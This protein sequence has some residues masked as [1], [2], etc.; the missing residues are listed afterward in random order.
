MANSSKLRALR[1]FLG[2]TGYY[3]KFIRGYALLAAPLTNLLKKDGFKWD[4]SST[5]AFTKLKMAM[6]IPPV[7]ALPDFTQPFIIECDAS[8][9][10]LGVVLMPNG[11]PLAFFSQMLHGK[12]LLL[13]AY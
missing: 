5:L 11:H 12:N 8:G 13:S 9:T 4:D 1:D 7:L 6:T 10:G 2:L 3:H